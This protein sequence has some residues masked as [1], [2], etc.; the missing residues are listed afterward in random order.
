MPSALSGN[1]LSDWLESQMLTVERFHQWERSA[2]LIAASI[3]GAHS[4]ARGPPLTNLSS[5]P[6]NFPEHAIEDDEGEEESDSVETNTVNQH[7][8][9]GTASG[10][11]EF[12][13][14]SNPRRQTN[15]IKAISALVLPNEFVGN[16]PYVKNR[17]LSQNPIEYDDKGAQRP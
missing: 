6:T 1:R 15:T 7:G 5:L 8:D 9:K 16:R 2:F 3:N 17:T 10:K 4:R 12:D 11:A 13:D 14:D